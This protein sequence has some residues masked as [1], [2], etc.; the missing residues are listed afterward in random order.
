MNLIEQCPIRRYRDGRGAADIDKVVAEARIEL[1]LNDDPRRIAMLCLPQDLDALAVGFLHGEG[2]LRSRQDLAGVQVDP[3]ARRVTIEGDLDADALDAVYNRWT[4]GTGCGGGGTGRDFDAPRYDRVPAGPTLSPETLRQLAEDFHSR[5]T[6]W[7]QTGGVHACA[8]AAEDG[9]VL[10]AEDVG[11]HNAFDKVLGRA[12]LDAVKLDDK[13]VLATGRLGGD[14]FQG[15]R[16]RPAHAGVAVG[17]DGAGGR[18][19]QAVRADPDRVHA[20]GAIERVH[21]VRAHPAVLK[22]IRNSK[23]EIRNKF[24]AR[25]SKQHRTTQS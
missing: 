18:P 25:N 7:N 17:G 24:E 13:L 9:I 10:S 23:H 1:Q 16:L 21:G 15:H 2:I 3:D 8:L 4:W 19:G 5:Q 6:L 14:R 22:Q 12:L 11:R 20:G